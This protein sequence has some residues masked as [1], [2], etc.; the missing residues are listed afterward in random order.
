MVFA[1][2]PHGQFSLSSLFAATFICAVIFAAFRW[3][4]LTPRTS[5]FVSAVATACLAAA[6]ALMAAIV[7]SLSDDSTSDDDQN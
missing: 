5:L 7:N 4:G 3:L 6:Y 1:S 2:S